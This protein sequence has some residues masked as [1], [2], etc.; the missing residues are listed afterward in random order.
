MVAVL[1]AEGVPSLDATPLRGEGLLAFARRLCGTAEVAPQLAEANGGRRLQEGVRYRVPLPLLAAELQE[2]VLR[3]LFPADRLDATGWHHTVAL[4]ALQQGESLW[5]VATRFTGDGGNFRQIREANRLPDDELRPGQ[6][7]WIPAGLLRPGLQRALPRGL[8]AVPG[9]ALEYHGE[10]TAPY[11]TY[12]LQPGEALYS[13]V[14]VRFTG[15]VFAEDVNA[16]AAEIAQASGISDVTDIPIGYQVKIPYELLLPEFLPAAHPRRVEY[17]AGL[18]DSNRFSNQVHSSGLQGITV[19]LDSG[20]GGADVGASMGGV[21]ES[22]Y[23]YDIMVRVKEM[24]ERQTAA[25]V[26]PTVRDGSGYAVSP[27]DVLPFS[28]AHQ[29][30]TTPPYPIADA[31]VGVNLRWYLANSHHRKAVAGDGDAR[32]VI[33]VSIHA[34]SLHPSLRGAMV[35]IPAAGLTAGRSSRTGDAYDAR[36]EVRE[37]RVVELSWRQRVESEG[38]SREMAERTIAAFRARGLPV[39]PFKPVRERIIRKRSEFVPAVLRY[40]TI[41]AKMLVEV[42]NLAN[43]QDRRMIQ[44][45]EFRQRMAEAIVAGIRDYFGEGEPGGAGVQVAKAK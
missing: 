43:D 19:V 39:H 7:L 45:R 44:T 25:R 17:E 40:N 11:A 34:D 23:V 10:A 41:P 22:L 24:L 3:A 4:A 38:L 31:R 30:L 42:C 21:W 18:S 20:H 33:F 9:A 13:S 14:V 35:Y 29:V 28:R 15:R 32:K 16:L 37:Q 26:V 2:K 8:L 12:R 27:A 36:Q 6:Q 1:T 5:T